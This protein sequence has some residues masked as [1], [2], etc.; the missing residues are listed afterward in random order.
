MLVLAAIIESYLRQSHLSTAARFWFAGGSAVFWTL[1]I[2]YGVVR[3]RAER[4]APLASLDDL[5]ADGDGAHAEDEHVLI[6]SLPERAALA[7]GL[8][9]RLARG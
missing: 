6:P 2:V 1:Y 4:L 7:A 9:E 8:L 3:E 5:G